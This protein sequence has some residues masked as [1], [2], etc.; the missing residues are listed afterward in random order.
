MAIE[1]KD[2]SASVEKWA[3]R[4]AAASGLYA[5]EAEKKADKW[6][7]N[8]Q[9]AQGN[10]QQGISA[11]GVPMRFARGVAKA[12]SAKF[13][14]MIREKGSGR[15]SAG[16]SIGKEEYKSD[17]EPFF[18][19]LAALTLSPRKMRGDPSNLNRVSEVA[20][21]L[22]AKRLALLAAGG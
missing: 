16:V 22:N 8:A 3:S 21:A 4:A 12:G 7:K 1:V 11:A 19:T 2:V 20:K 10:Y 13:A 5:E 17:V 18:S 14:R 9:G 6:V 15:Y